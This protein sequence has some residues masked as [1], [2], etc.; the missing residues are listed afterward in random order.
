MR[1]QGYDSDHS[2]AF[3]HH[4]LP[5]V[6][7]TPADR[8]LK[9]VAT[10]GRPQK[11]CDHCRS[12]R[13][14]RSH[15]ARCDCGEKMEQLLGHADGDDSS[16]AVEMVEHD[17][18]C[19]HGGPCV[20]GKKKG[21]GSTAAQHILAGRS[22]FPAL[23]ST[24]RLT[25]AIDASPKPGDTPEDNTDVPSIACR[26]SQ[27]QAP[28][29]P[30]AEQA[31]YTSLASEPGPSGMQENSIGN[32]ALDY[33]GSNLFTSPMDLTHYPL[34]SLSWTGDLDAAGLDAL[35]LGYNN[36]PP[37]ALNMASNTAP[38]PVPPADIQSN[39]ALNVEQWTDLNP[40]PSSIYDGNDF[41]AWHDP[42]LSIAGNAWDVPFTNLD[43]LWSAEGLPLDL[44]VISGDFTQPPL[45]GDDF[46]QRGASGPDGSS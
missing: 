2:Q 9:P 21:P 15:H 11:Q 12:A 32:P 35:G 18:C 3:D 43:P 33:G 26:A 40:L 20:C 4:T 31:A 34:D 5:T 46:T 1:P 28:R 14:S 38:S 42:A 22:R 17:C 16:S 7:D 37:E 36:L 6:A 10:K 41:L 19:I 25:K 30:I 45:H 24:R 13:K 44:N 39:E 27:P 8:E 29:G 23:S